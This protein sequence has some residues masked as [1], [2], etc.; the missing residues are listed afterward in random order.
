MEAA[1]AERTSLVPRTAASI[2]LSPSSRQRKIDSSTTIELSTNI[3]TPKANP[4]SDIILTL[5]WKMCIGA[6]VE[7][8][9]M[10]MA[11]PTIMV[12]TTL[13]RKKKRTNIASIPPKIA[14]LR[15]SAIDF[16]I[17]VDWSERMSASIP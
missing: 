7:M 3:P 2:R 16:L 13:R 14:V 9:D 15:T 5:T 11:A 8:M 4:P 17:N 12:D 10:G 6:K 1:T